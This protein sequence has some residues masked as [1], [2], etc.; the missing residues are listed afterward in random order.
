ME[1]DPNWGSIPE[2]REEQ[3]SAARMGLALLGLVEGFGDE[4]TA[5]DHA[6]GW[7]LACCVSGVFASLNP[8]DVLNLRGIPGREGITP[9]SDGVQECNLILLGATANQGGGSAALK[10]LR[11]WLL[12]LADTGLSSTAPKAF[13]LHQ[14]GYLGSHCRGPSLHPSR[15]SFF[16]C[17]VVR[18]IQSIPACI[19]VQPARKRST[20]TGERWFCMDDAGLPSIADTATIVLKTR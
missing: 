12:N 15:F 7:L 5:K 13:F 11:E 8:K 14:R 19:S 2:L 20:I 10:M 9:R 18:R 4:V 1:N 16:F 3:E 6:N 17:H